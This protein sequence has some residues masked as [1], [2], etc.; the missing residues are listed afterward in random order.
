MRQIK[1]P[2]TSPLLLGLLVVVTLNQWARIVDDSSSSPTAIVAQG[3]ERFPMN[4]LGEA[5]SFSNYW[6]VVEAINEIIGPI[7]GEGGGA[8]EG[9]ASRTIE[10]VVEVLVWRSDSKI[11]LSNNFNMPLLG[12]AVQ[13]GQQIPLNYEGAQR[14]EIGEKYL[15]GLIVEPEGITLASPRAVFKMSGGLVDQVSDA[16]EHGDLLNRLV[17]LSA[18]EVGRELSIASPAVPDSLG[19]FDERL[20]I[21]NK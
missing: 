21:Y 12:Y 9:Y 6:V 11:Q 16:K 14:M 7:E 5:R 20:E 2:R 1:F 3:E 4:S 18:G 15:I 13:D 19:T 8:R 10:V 17:G